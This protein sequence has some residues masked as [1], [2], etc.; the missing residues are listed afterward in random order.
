MFRLMLKVLFVLLIGLSGRFMIKSEKKDFED[1]K[2]IS[3][4]VFPNMEIL[5]MK[6][7]S[8]KNPIF[9]RLKVTPPK[10]F[11]RFAILQI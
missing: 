11:L 1:P 3:N 6:V 10:I 5:E 4:L 9:I 2:D 8:S 7:V